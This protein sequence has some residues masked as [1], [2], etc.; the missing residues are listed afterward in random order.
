MEALS[1]DGIATKKTKRV[2]LVGQA[3]DPCSPEIIVVCHTRASQML[4]GNHT[5]KQSMEA[6]DFCCSTLPLVFSGP[7]R[8]SGCVPLSLISA[9]DFTMD[10]PEMMN[11]EDL[12][13][14][15]GGGRE[16]EI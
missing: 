12:K 4:L 9:N 10:I 2:C 5:T 11:L 7:C 6:K 1:L 16:R 8:F 13:M 14:L 15:G 3:W